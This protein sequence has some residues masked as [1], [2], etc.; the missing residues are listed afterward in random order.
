MRKRSILLSV[1][2]SAAVALSSCGESDLILAEESVKV[3]FSWWGKDLRNNYTITAL[4]S[5]SKL[6]PDIDVKADFSE[7]EASQNRE[8]VKHSSNEE[9]DVMQIY[10]EWL[11]R[12][13]RDGEAFYDLNKLSDIIDLTTFSED[14]LSYGTVNGKLVGLPVTLNAETFYYNKSIYDSFG[15][16]IPSKWS[17]VFKAA[18]VMSKEGIYPLEMD[19]TSAW[20]SCIAHQEQICNKHSYDQDGNLRFSEEDF[21]SMLTFYKSLIDG[22]VIKHYGEADKTSFQN[23]TSAGAVYWISNAGY[24]CQPLINKGV[25]VVIG[26]Y[27]SGGDSLIL[28]WHAKPTALY[29]IKSST[30]HPTE[31]AKLV[32]FL[33]NSQEMAHLQ[34]TEKGIPLSRAMLEVLESER[35]LSGIQFE[36]NNKLKSTK[37]IDRISPFLEDPDLIDAF[38]SAINSMLYEGKAPEE[39][40]QSVYKAALDAGN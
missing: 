19:K 40:A 5:F 33:V 24:Y 29:C 34:G 7:L 36:A 17:D 20:L 11:Y 30:E 21:A 2:A 35:S 27:L 12:F 16:P 3:S 9:S 22:K 32:D 15:L 28:G 14:E 6:N 23:G 25:K 37:R 10:Y 8:F 38:D 39:L 31:A 1:L 13:S 4:K 26:D 18:E